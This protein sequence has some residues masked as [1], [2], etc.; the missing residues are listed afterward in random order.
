[1]LGSEEVLVGIA[2]SEVLRIGEGIEVREPTSLTI[3]R[4]EEAR[5]LIPQILVALRTCS[6]L[7]CYLTIAHPLGIG[8]DGSIVVG[9]LQCLGDTLIL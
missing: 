4:T 9:I 3:L 8:C 7:L 6:I 2:L 1:M 5:A